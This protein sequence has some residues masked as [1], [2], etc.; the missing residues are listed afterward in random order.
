ME[1]LAKELPQ[2]LERAPRCGPA[3]LEL[4]AQ[5]PEM[6]MKRDTGSTV[7]NLLASLLA[8]AAIAGWAGEALCAHPIQEVPS[9]TVLSKDN[10]EIAKGL[11]PE[12]ILALYQRG[13]YANPIQQRPGD[14]WLIDPQLAAASKQNAGRFDVDANGTVVDKATGTRPPVITGLPFPDIDA[15]DPKA[16]AKVMWN[17]FYTLYWEGTFHNSSPVNW[18]SRD[19]ATRRMTTDVHFKYYDGQHPEQQKKLSENT[20]N[21]LSRALTVIVEPSDVNGIV[22]L[23]WRYR[24]GDKQDNA[25]S[26]VPAIRRI[27]PVNPANRADGM[28]GSDISQDDG[29]YFDGKPEAFDFK[30]IGE[31]VALANFDLPALQNGSPVK[32]L[33]VDEQISSRITNP[34]GGFHTVVPEYTLVASQQPEW[35]RA[36]GEGLVA[37]APLQWVLVPRPVWIVEAVPKDPY[38]IYGKQIMLIDKATHRG[39]WKNKYDWKGNALANWAPTAYPL[40]KIK[41]VHGVEQYAR[42]GGGGGIAISNNFKHDRA[43]VTG[44]PVKPAQYRIDIP[45]EVFL[46]ERMVRYGK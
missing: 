6:S 37:W 27:R 40:T 33:R 41:D 20:L 21:L 17:W 29:A 8:A 35:R 34:G 44:M 24:E 5:P 7:R 14:E 9:G 10:W 45:D 18:L 30:L 43:T 16:G 28:M 26:Y 31:G 1:S 3:A 32:P 13:E 12:E 19:G 36:D 22:S 46:T 25:W 2:H 39:Y 15:N 42:T 11:L 23:M 38:Y 4:A